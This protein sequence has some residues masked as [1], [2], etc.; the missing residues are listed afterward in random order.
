MRVRIDLIKRESRSKQSNQPRVVAL[1]CVVILDVSI[2]LVPKKSFIM[3]M[4]FTS[5][6]SLFENLHLS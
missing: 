4:V 3:P 1:H 2:F 5:A 6:Y